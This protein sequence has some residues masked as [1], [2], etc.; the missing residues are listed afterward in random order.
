VSPVNGPPFSRGAIPTLTGREQ[1]TLSRLRK[2]LQV[3]DI[4]RYIYDLTHVDAQGCPPDGTGDVNG[5]YADPP[6]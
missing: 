2:K 3:G 5:V 1:R 6:G 4:V